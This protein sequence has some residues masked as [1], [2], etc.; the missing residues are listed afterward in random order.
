[1][2]S[3]LRSLPE[4]LS[5]VVDGSHIALGGFAITRCVM[6]AVH[7]LVRRGRRDLTVSQ[8]VGGMDTDLLVAGGGVRRLVYS[9]GSLERFGPLPAINAAVL[10]GSLVVEEYSSLTLAGRFHAG[11][12]GMPFVAGRSLLGSDLL[13]PLLQTPD[14]RLGEDPFTGTPVVLM[15]PL[16]PD[17]AIVHVEIADELGNGALCGP[18][19]TIRDTALSARR[20]VLLCEELVHRLPP[21]QVMIPGAVVDAVSVV[22]R[23][24]HPTAVLGRYAYDRRHIEA[25]VAAGRDGSAGLRRYLDRY[26][27]G[28]RSHTDYLN[29]VGGL[30]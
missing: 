7:E 1:M 4:A 6:A 22:P 5:A 28:V 23:S 20:V 15:A 11:A 21:E 18:S 29:L 17:L 19:W 2:T 14:V 12:L 8:C 10:A 13:E 9:G 16:H 27:L 30:P 24:A 25:Y 3:K 26:V